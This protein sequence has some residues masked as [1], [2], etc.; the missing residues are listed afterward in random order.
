MRVHFSDSLGNAAPA[1]RQE[2]AR[3]NA[4]MGVVIYLTFTRRAVTGYPLAVRH[5]SQLASV[6]S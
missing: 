3:V 2:M 1:R 4:K 5:D 6:R